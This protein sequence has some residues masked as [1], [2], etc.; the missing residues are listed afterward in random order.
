MIVGVHRHTDLGSGETP[1]MSLQSKE[2]ERD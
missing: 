2:S 1:V